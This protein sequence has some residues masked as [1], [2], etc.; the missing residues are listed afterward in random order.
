MGVPRVI[1]GVFGLEPL[2]S[3]QVRP[4]GPPPFARAP[5]LWTVNG[6][7]AIRV[8]S[9]ALRP[10]QVWV[11]SYLCDAVLVG[12]SDP[13][14]ARFYEVS[15]DLAVAGGAWLD[16]VRAGDLV[17]MIDY[18][19]FPARP[20]LV[21][22]VRGR[23][24]C[25]LEDACQAL[26][27]EGVGQEADFVV[28]SPRKF[29]G[30]PDGGLLVQTGARPLPVVDLALPPPAWWREARAA[31]EG[32]RDFDRGS[33][34][35]DWFP[36]FQR[37]EREAPSGAYAASELTRSILCGAVDWPGVSERRRA[38]WGILAAAL[39]D[40]A[41]FPVL[42]AGVVPLGFPVRTPLRDAVRDALFAHEI[43]PPVHW[44]LVGVVPGRFAGSHRLAAEIMTL[45]C[46]QRY[47]GTEMERMATLVRGALG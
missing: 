40:V 23:G 18:F 2:P 26:L 46:D 28:F 15:A 38:N 21:A 4:N 34:G 24:A 8:L 36:A 20:D 42:P 25:V 45:P 31:T 35:R 41:V 17:V 27:T 32:R 6:R 11:P 10:R 39:G 1:G 44:P 12:L 9:H 37:A 22:A 3:A 7:S 33:G 16:E 30:V 29:V 43:Y 13:G 14:A 47:E 5:A 19:G